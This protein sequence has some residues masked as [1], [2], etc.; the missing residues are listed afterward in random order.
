MRPF[1][2]SP[3]VCAA[4]RRAL[5][6]QLPD[7][8]VVLLPSASLQTRSRDTEYPFRQA[9]DFWYLTGFDEPDAL[10]VLVPGREQGEVLL[11]NPPRD[12]QLEIW[13]GYRLGQIRAPQV[14]GVD[15][16]FAN[17]E[18]D[19]RLPALLDG[20]QHICYPLDDDFCHQ[21]VQDWRLALRSRERRGACVPESLINLTPFLDEMRLI[22]QPEEVALMREAARISAEAH[23][24]AM[25]CCRPG[26]YEYQLQA[27]LEHEFLWQGGSGPAYGTIVGGGANGCVLHYVENHAPLRDGDLVLIDAGCEYAG[28]AGDI[29]RTFPV[30][31]RFNE[32]QKALYS[33]VL[34][35]NR[36][37]ISQ[38]K[39]GATL[40]EVHETA[41]RHLTWGLIQLGIL[42]GDIDTLIA[43]EAYRDFYMHGTSHWL[44]LDVHDVGLYKPHGEARKLVP[45]MV[46]TIEPGLYIAPDQPDVD[47]CWRGIGI[48]VEDDVLVTDTGCEILTDGVPKSIQEIEALMQ[49]D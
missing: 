22:K 4:R 31:G 42:E 10:L 3:E 21:R 49:A 32:A 37:A 28:Y 24:R 33:L 25:K 47:E 48:R 6:E 11:F 5:L 44:G 41:V 1:D 43:D 38:V 23:V 17:D 46:L 8:V 16:A 19:Q 15:Q 2:V 45:G 14:L 30:N 9:S 29:T 39:P 35:A 27:E 13:H 20:C 26:L 40:P 36:L 7:D 34:E 18:L 12:E